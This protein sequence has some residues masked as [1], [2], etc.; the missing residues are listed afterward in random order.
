M[1]IEFDLTENDIL[2]LVR[3]R[4]EYSPVFRQRILR[5]RYGY[6]V[7]FSLLGI[8]SLLISQKFLPFAFFLLAVVSFLLFPVFNDWRLKRS[9]SLAYQD[10]NKRAT[11]EKRIMRA[12][13]EGL[14]EISRFGETK[15][16]WMVIDNI[17][18][19]PTH[20]FISIDQLPT[21][22]IPKDKV[23]EN[24]EE[25]VQACQKF[26]ENSSNQ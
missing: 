15:V 20:A 26:Q 6:L 17:S 18:V 8:G 16:K 9:V 14:E 13:N 7:G 3:R 1:E 12:T 25:F 2:A 22:V 19:T 4:Q 24:F 21:I 5:L 11:L 23:K 10:K